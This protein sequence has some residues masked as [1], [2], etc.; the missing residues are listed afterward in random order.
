MPAATRGERL[1]ARD[2]NPKWK[3]VPLRIEMSECI[4]CDTCIRHCPPQ[5]GA[6][7]NHGIDVIIIPELC[8]GCGK[9]LARVPGR[10]HLRRPG[11][12]ARAR[13]TGG[14]SPRP[15]TPTPENAHPRRRAVLVAPAGPTAPWCCTA[16][17]A[18][19]SRCG[20]WPRRSPPRASP[21]SCRSCPA[22]APWSRTWSRPGGRTGRARPRRAYQ[23]LAG[24]CDK[25]V[26]A[27]L[28]MGGT[29]DVLAGRPPPRDRRHRGRQPGR[30]APGRLV[31]RHLPGLAR[32]RARGHPRHRQRRGRPRRQRSWPTTETPLAA[33]LSLFEAI[34]ELAPRLGDIRCPVLLMNSP[35]DHVVPPSNADFLAERVSGPLE[36]V[37]A[38]PQLPR[39]HARLRQ[40]RH[41]AARRGVRPARSL[42]PSLGTTQQGRTSANGT[43][44]R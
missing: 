28:S 41:R 19:R 35:Q 33:A 23:E 31:P 10:L 4:N 9:C 40:G 29:L 21:S 12:D 38:R 16:S 32:R 30:R 2:R 7:F 15:M 5:F 34:T 24:R 42:L 20:A 13:T 44:H 43:R 1:D 26:V 6:I 11:L 14:R 39:G 17:P 18:T 37:I 36:R 22:T 25:V 3:N 27:G 8:S